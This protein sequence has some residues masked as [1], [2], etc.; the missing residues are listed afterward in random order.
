MSRRRRQDRGPRPAFPYVWSYT[1]K[2]DG[3]KGQRCRIVRTKGRGIVGGTVLVEF[4]DRRQ[5]FVARG[6]LEKANP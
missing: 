3:R 1:Q 6:G 4:A 5:F 2:P